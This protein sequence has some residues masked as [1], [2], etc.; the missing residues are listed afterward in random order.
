MLD[1]ISKEIS[2]AMLL[3]VTSRNYSNDR[4]QLAENGTQKKNQN[5]KMKL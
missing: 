1:E 4:C 3:Y 2:F 5:G